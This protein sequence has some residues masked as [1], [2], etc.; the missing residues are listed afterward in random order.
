M[1]EIVHVKKLGFT[2]IEYIFLYAIKKSHLTN[3]QPPF[4]IFL[5]VKF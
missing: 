3:L 5:C 4:L 1:F 2:C